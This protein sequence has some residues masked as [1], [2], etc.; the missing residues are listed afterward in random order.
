MTPQ[1]LRTRELRVDGIRTVLRRGDP[2]GLPGHV[3][4]R[5]LT[6]VTRVKTVGS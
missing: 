4:G 5:S 1:S 6:F 2:R 3:A